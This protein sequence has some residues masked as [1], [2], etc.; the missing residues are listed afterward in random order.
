MDVTNY[1]AAKINDENL[2]AEN[3]AENVTV[4]GITGTFRGGI[5][6]SDGDVTAGD[7][8]AGKVAYAKE[9]RIVGAIETYNY[10]NSENE[11]TRNSLK[12]LL[13]VTKSLNYL[14]ANSSITTTSGLIAYNDTENVTTMDRTFYSCTKLT[15]ITL[16]NIENVTSMP[17]TFAGS[18][19]IEYLPLF[20]PIKVKAM[21]GMCQDCKA[22]KIFPSWNMSS[23]TDMSYMLFGCI[24]LEEVSR[25]STPKVT[26][27][28]S[29]FRG[30]YKLKIVDI[31]R[32]NIS[33][34]TN[35]N[36]M[37]NSCYSLKAFVIRSFG[38][39][40]VLNSNS[41]SDCYHLLG[42]VNSTYNP[43]GLQDGY[44]YVPRDMI[45][46]LSGATNWSTIATQLRALED[47]TLDGTTTG[48]LDLAKMGLEV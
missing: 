32:Y 19:V 33:S 28:S 45:E 40:Y 14:C 18:S 7:I 26:T 10:S 25:I 36:S 42:T 35:S 38:S 11:D 15:E 39:N 5:D 48:D 29:S 12:R 31:S 6:T 1:A 4:L 2:T 27:M 16:F 13:D 23:V 34:T 43:D 41:F 9:E 22:L 30:C 44:I 3:I 24:S 37:C 46:T 47:Y 8:L 17:Y 20:N 21:N